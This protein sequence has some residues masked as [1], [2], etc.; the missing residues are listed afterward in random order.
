MAMSANYSQTNTTV[1]STVDGVT[2]L[3]DDDDK[4]FGNPWDNTDPFTSAYT[5]KMM[6][7]AFICY[8]RQAILFMGIPGN[9]ICCAVFVKQGLSDRINLLLFWLAVIDFGHLSLQFPSSIACYTTDRVLIHNVEMVV[10]AQISRMFIAS[11]KISGNLVVVMSVERCLHV[12][13]PF[14]ARRLL[15]YR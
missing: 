1:V 4:V 13:I 5:R 11:G 7:Y 9:A 2:E 12:V 10:Y 6:S 15:T 3:T 8:I 14:R